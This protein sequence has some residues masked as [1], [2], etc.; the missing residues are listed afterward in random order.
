MR[1]STQAQKRLYPLA[2]RLIDPR[3]PGPF[4]EAMM[5]LGATICRKARPACL[6]CP[7]KAHCRAYARGEETTV[8]VIIR[9]ATSRR[10]VHRLWLRDRDRILLTRYPPK[11]PGLPD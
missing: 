8:P 5:E 7:V 4:N 3:R 6:L 10:E 11:L 1:T 9:K 2:S